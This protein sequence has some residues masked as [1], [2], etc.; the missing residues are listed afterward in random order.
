MVHICTKFALAVWKGLSG[1]ELYS[2]L[3]LSHHGTATG[4]Q[5]GDRPGVDFAVLT[6]VK[7]MFK[8]VFMI[9]YMIE[10]ISMRYKTWK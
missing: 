2:C 7:S 10:F 6:E 8:H 1:H 3:G 4:R 5:A 9:I